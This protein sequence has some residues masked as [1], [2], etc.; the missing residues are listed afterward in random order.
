LTKQE[1][2]E[3]INN[4]TKTAAFHAG[5]MRLGDIKKQLEN[6]IAANV[7]TPQDQAGWIATVEDYILDCIRSYSV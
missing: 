1:L 5:C 2:I 3:V 4:R 6:I 7:V